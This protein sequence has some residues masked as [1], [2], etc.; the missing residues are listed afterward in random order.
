MILVVDDDADVVFFL[1]RVLEREGY[2]VAEAYSGEECLSKLSE[3]H[4][5]LVILDIMM[6][7]LDGWEVCRRIKENPR[8]NSIPVL[9]VS[10]K[11]DDEDV[12]NSMEYARADGH[13]GKPI[14]LKRL[15]VAVKDLLETKAPGQPPPSTGNSPGSSG[16][17]F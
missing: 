8:T 15:T 2:S 3:V 5:K 6:P 16:Q 11:K 4:P 10:V 14:D 17:A 1:K 9:M 12:K 7:G 13:L